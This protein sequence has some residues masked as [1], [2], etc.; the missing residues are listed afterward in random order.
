LFGGGDR[1]AALHRISATL[2]DGSSDRAQQQREPQTRPALPQLLTARLVIELAS[3]AHAVLHAR[4]FSRNREH[5]ARWNPPLED[6][7]SEGFWKRSLPASVAEF[8]AGRSLRLVALPRESPGERLVARINFTQIVRGA[9]HSCM[10][11]FAVDRDDEGRGLM[12][13]ALAASIDWIF[14]TM[15]LHRIQASHLPENERSRR[16]LARLGFAPEGLARQYLY[17][18]GAWRDHVINA[19]LNPHFDI[20]VLAQQ[21]GRAPP[22]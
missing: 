18:A 6:V 14:A 15:N 8:E 11:G 13:E 20:G 10:L 5:F 16:L 4:H 22:N 3:P 9:F 17:I 7:E 1:G 21:A 12:T 2:V 19:R